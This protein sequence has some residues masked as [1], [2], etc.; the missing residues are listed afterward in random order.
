MHK[1]CLQINH[2]G[3]ADDLV[4]FN[5]RNNISINLVMKWLRNY[6]GASSQNINNDKKKNFLVMTRMTDLPIEK[7]KDE[8]GIDNL[9]FFFTYLGCPICLEKKGFAT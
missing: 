7:L 5:S 9:H 3:Y 8:Q 6:Q 4:L 2:L 1:T